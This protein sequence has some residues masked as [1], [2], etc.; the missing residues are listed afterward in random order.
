MNFN[1]NS[2][3][4]AFSLNLNQ[5][6]FIYSIIG[7]PI[8]QLVVYDTLYSLWKLTKYL[9]LLLS[10]NLIVMLKIKVKLYLVYY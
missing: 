4:H 8:D 7:D 5:Y 2:S 1:N 10:G 3:K 9:S 6:L